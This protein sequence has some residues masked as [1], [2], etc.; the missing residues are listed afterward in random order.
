MTGQ[1]FAMN[2][3]RSAYV[4]TWPLWSTSWLLRT[5]EPLGPPDLTIRSTGPPLREMNPK[6]AL[7]RDAVTW[8]AGR[9]CGRTHCWT[10]MRANTKPPSDAAIA[11][12][13]RR[14][15]APAA[16]ASMNAKNV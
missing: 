9:K 15:I 11:G 16:A 7:A 8:R 12:T 5:H 2:A 14:M 4:V 10:A 6:P 3:V 13:V 1:Y